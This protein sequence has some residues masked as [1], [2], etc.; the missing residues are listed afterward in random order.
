[1]RKTKKGTS[2]LIAGAMIMS[3][4][5]VNTAGV[6]AQEDNS[7]T[8]VLGAYADFKQG[9]GAE[10]HSLV[11][12]TMTTKAEDMSIQP[13]AI[14]SWTT[15][16]DMSQYTL[17]VRKDVKFSD[18][19]P[20][21]AEIIK[22]SLEA[23]APFRDGSYM[24]SVES[25][26]VVDDTTLLVNFDGSYGNFPVEIS[27]I[28]VSLPDSLD[29]N[30]NVTNWIGTG[31]FV[32][33]DYQLE[34]S[35]TLVPNENYWNTEKEPQIDKLEWLV[36]PDENAR[37][38]ALES[39][40]VD[41][42]GVTEHYCALSYAAISD[43]QS[44]EN[45]TVD[46]NPDS[47]LIATYVFNYADGPMTDINLRKAVVLGIDRQTMVDSIDYGIGEASGDFMSR[48]YDY[49]A[50]NEEPYEY[51]P[52]EAKAVLAEG[53][54]EDTDGDGIVEKDGEP[55]KLRFVVG[56]E[57]KERSAAVYVQECLRQIG[58]DTELQSLDESA[59]GEKEAAG[60]FDLAYTHPW[61]K[62]PQTYMAWRGN[63]NSYDD[64]GICFGINDN[65]EEYWKEVNTAKDKETL[66][67][68]FDKI[69]EE[70]YAFYPGVPLYTEPRAF[71]YSNEVSGF[72][73][74]PEETVIDLSGVAVDRNAE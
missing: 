72:V 41:A 11:F 21:T 22:Y 53:G 70:L 63:S 56:S 66:W 5:V 58:I 8:L 25:Y 1:M 60:D 6:Q 55:V 18:G 3:L 34:Q 9:S 17:N 74:D 51:D 35:A 40:Q 38:M 15:N 4:F 33:E 12:D 62:T 23:W 49:S 37:V 24:Y 28:F 52:E 10:G 71:I 42:I 69:W 19:T 59:R 14:E 61:L 31:P 26:E 50:R 16:E 32:L 47:G 73:F 43:L 13:G 44:N 27:R 45:F 30:G 7:N 64:F 39:G 46:I 48:K 36:I 67:A 29:E 20:L 57:E 68:V 54:Y 2:L 65:F